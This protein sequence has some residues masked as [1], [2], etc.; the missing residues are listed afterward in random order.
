MLSDRE[1]RN[2]DKNG[3]V[4]G[5]T[6]GNADGLFLEIDTSSEH[7]MKLNKVYTLFLHDLKKNWCGCGN[8]WTRLRPGVAHGVAPEHNKLP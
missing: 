6:G 7:K 5:G 1:A 8:A 2:H 4:Q 3:C